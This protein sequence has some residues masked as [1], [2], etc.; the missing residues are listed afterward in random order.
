MVKSQ[1]LLVIISFKILGLV[2]FLDVVD[3][4]LRF[5]EYAPRSKKYC[6]NHSI[7]YFYGIV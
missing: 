4:V 3:I 2:C 6:A 1:W 7:H 5:A